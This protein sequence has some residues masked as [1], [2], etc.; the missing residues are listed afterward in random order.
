MLPAD[1][2][3]KI[4]LR[5]FQENNEPKPVKRDDSRQKPHISPFMHQVGHICVDNLSLGAAL[6]LQFGQ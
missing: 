2:K 5:Q 1:T 3:V 4:E 6:M